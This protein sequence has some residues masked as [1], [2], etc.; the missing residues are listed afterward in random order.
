FRVS[1]CV[2]DSFGPIIPQR[3]KRQ[4]IAN[5]IDAATIFART[6]FV[7]VHSSFVKNNLYPVCAALPHTAPF[8]VELCTDGFAVSVQFLRAISCFSLAEFN[9]GKG[10]SELRPAIPLVWRIRKRVVAPCFLLLSL[11]SRL[12]FDG[13]RSGLLADKSLRFPISRSLLW[14]HC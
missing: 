4:S 8:L 1:D 12:C 2:R 3:A 10:L 13:V 7:S 5:Q 6:D 11:L 14:R 9:Y